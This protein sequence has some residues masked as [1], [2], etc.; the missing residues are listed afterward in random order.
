M[1][2]IYDL[3][4]YL[5]KLEEK[6]MKPKICRKKIFAIKAKIK[7]IENWGEKTKRWFLETIKKT[8]KP[9]ARMIKENRE[10]KYKSPVSG[11]KRTSLQIL[12]TL[13]E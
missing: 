13:K 12:Q 3:S 10:T 1:L 6:Q 11:E 4:F 2:T 8:K 5:K 7:E 9:L